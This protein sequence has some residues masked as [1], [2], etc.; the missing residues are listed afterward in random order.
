MNEAIVKQRFD[1]WIELLKKT[2]NE[3]L[4]TDP[5]N[6]WLEAW[7]VSSLHTEKKDPAETGSNTST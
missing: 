5:Y 7:F 2:K 4:L 6:I 1:E 3:D